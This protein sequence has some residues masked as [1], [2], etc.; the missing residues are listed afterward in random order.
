M[1]YKDQLV[2][3]GEINDIGSPVFV[4]VPKSYRLGVEEFGLGK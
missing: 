2:Q 4:N 1:H 3:T